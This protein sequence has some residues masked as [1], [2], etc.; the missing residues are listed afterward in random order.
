[1]VCRSARLRCHGPRLGNVLGNDPRLAW[2]RY[3]AETGQPIPWVAVH[4]LPDYVYFH[5]GVHVR[6]GISCVECH[7]PVHQMDEVYQAQPLSMAF[8]L[9]CHRNPAARLRPPETVF[10]LG[11]RWHGQPQQAAQLRRQFGQR[12]MQDW[13]VESLQACSACHR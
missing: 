9:E 3:S 11:W 4:R 2:V 13:N 6:R 7:G 5:H 10:D 8:C 1:V 12:A